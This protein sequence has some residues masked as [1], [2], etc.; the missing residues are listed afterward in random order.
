MIVST[1]F[2]IAHDGGDGSGAPDGGGAGMSF[3]RQ[4]NLLLSSF[5]AMHFPSS[6]LS[7]N[8]TVHASPSFELAHAV[9][10][11]GGG[12]CGCESSAAAIAATKSNAPARAK[13]EIRIF[14]NPP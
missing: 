5:D 14:M 12:P 13:I 3:G 1:D 4:N 7:L 10:A 8:C 6:V 11:S 2:S 9:N